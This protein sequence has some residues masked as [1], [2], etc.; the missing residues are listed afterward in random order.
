MT[1]IDVSLLKINRLQLPYM[2]HTKVSNQIFYRHP[3]NI[4]SS[5]IPTNRK[6]LNVPTT[7]KV[8]LRNGSPK[9]FLICSST[10]IETADQTCY[11]TQGQYYTVTRTLYHHTSGSL[12]TRVPILK[13]L[14][15]PVSDPKILHTQSRCLTTVNQNGKKVNMDM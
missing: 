14:T 11:L 7:C 9:Q 13:W 10:V 8:Y 1:P 3:H 15:Q 4:I 6:L 12:A 2:V 5:M